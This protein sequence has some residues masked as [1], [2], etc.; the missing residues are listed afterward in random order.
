MPNLWDN[1]ITYHICWCNS[2]FHKHSWYD[3]VVLLNTQIRELDRK[4]DI[5][6]YS[7]GRL[8]LLF[9]FKHETDTYYLA[10]IQHFY[11]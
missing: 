2:S 3:W 6:D 4:G 1:D 8:Q 9:E 10:Y 11:R 7:I 5:S